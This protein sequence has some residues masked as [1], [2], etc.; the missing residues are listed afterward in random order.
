ML[1]LCH[2]MLKCS[3]SLGRI[4]RIYPKFTLVQHLNNSVKND[5]ICDLH[6]LFKVT[7]EKNIHANVGQKVTVCSISPER[8]YKEK[9]MSITLM[10][11]KNMIK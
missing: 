4:G 5:R 2:K 10:H 7:A 9:W 11:A 6:L 8:V 3:L 1:Y